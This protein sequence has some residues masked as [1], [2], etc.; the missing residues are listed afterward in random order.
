MIGAVLAELVW[1]QFGAVRASPPVIVDHL[2]F[3]VEDL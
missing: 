2:T 1:R 3:P